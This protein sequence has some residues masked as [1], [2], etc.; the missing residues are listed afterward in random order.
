MRCTAGPA[1]LPVLHE[2]PTQNSAGGP[3]GAV[4]G[5]GTP[6]RWTSVPGGSG[7]AVVP[8]TLVHEYSH[9]RFTVVSMGGPSWSGTAFLFLEVRC[10]PCSTISMPSRSEPHR[11]RH[12]HR[13]RAAPDHHGRLP[14]LLHLVGRPEVPHLRAEGPA[15]Q[16]FD[17]EGPFLSAG[18]KL[19][20]TGHTAFSA[21]T[22]VR[23]KIASTGKASAAVPR[24]GGPADRLD[25]VESFDRQMADYRASSMT[26]SPTST[27]TSASPGMRP[28]RGSARS[29]TP[30]TPRDA[31]RP[32]PRRLGLPGHRAARVPG[33]A[34]ARALRREEERVHA[35]SR[36]RS[37][38]PSRR[39]SR[40]SPQWSIA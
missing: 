11:A 6:C 9:L 3:P 19:L 30:R 14:G 37:G 12:D 38:W 15:A 13:R 4:K 27:A 5:Y 23:D 7:K 40:S 39:S 26:P 18:K 34:D 16:A 29:S 31:D 28:P 25:D 10:P 8:A 24:P 33:P 21:V 1:Y 20:D 17:A 32:V 36:R 2:V 22:A 35:R